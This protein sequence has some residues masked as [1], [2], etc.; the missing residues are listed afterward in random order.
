M[1]F[2]A[3]VLEGLNFEARL[4]RMLGTTFGIDLAMFDD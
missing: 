2:T 3:D 4:G 1:T